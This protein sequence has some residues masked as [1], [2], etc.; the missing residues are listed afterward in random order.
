MKQ[1]KHYGQK[2][3]SVYVF[4]LFYAKL[5][6]QLKQLIMV[7]RADF[8]RALVWHQISGIINTDE[9]TQITV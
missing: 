9:K 7:E 6:A 3:H 4:P 2:V 1:W 5:V 8:V